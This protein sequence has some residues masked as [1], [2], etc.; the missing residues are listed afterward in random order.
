[1]FRITFSNTLW[2]RFSETLRKILFFEASY[3]YDFGIGYKDVKNVCKYWQEE[4]TR[5]ELQR[6]LNENKLVNIANEFNTVARIMKWVNQTYPQRIFYKKDSGD[7]WNTPIETLNSFRIRK[8]IYDVRP[9]WPKSVYELD[10]AWKSCKSTDCDDYAILLY[11]LCRVAGVSQ[12]KLY[13]CW[14]KTLTE[15]HMNVMYFSDGVPYAL[16]GTYNPD[17]AMQKFGRENYFNTEYYLYVR[18]I[19]NED[20]VFRYSDKIN[21]L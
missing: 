3:K 18:W 7:T 14:M 13:L 17:Q 15:W 20:K 21:Q 1:M 12:D 19:W 5:F 9:G 10:S 2:A 16:E 4:T 11:S 8:L 6:V